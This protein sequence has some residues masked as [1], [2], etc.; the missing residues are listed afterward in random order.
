MR[1]NFQKE[2]I[3]S[4]NKLHRKVSRLDK[5]YLPSPFSSEDFRFYPKERDWKAI[6]NHVSSVLLY[7]TNNCNSS[8][9]I[10]YQESKIGDRGGEMEKE[11][12]QKV[13]DRI[14]KNKRVTLIGGEP[15]VRDDLFE[16]IRMVKEKGHEPEIFTNG[17]KLSDIKYV[18]KLK[19]AGIERVYISLDGFEE[20]IYEKMRGD[21]S[22][23]KAKLLALRNLEAM[24]MS[25]VI[26]SVI[27]KDINE[28]QIESL[29]EFGLD[30]IRESTDHIDGLLF[31][32]LT[33]TGRCELREHE[34]STVELLKLLK[35]ETN[36]QVVPEY[37]IETKKLALNISR[38]MN[39]LNMPLNFGSGGLIGLY[40]PGSIEPCFP[41]EK[42]I[43]LNDLLERGDIFRFG[44]ESLKTGKIRKMLGNFI[45]GSKIIDSISQ[46]NLFLGIGGVNNP[47]SH[48]SRMT[49]TIGLEASPNDKIMVNT[50]SFRD[51]ES[52]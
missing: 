18:K 15:T 26:A 45:S 51:L 32:G 27:G 38:L 17:L 4:K 28:D 47:S 1:G 21:A 24:E 23:L 2:E 20:E 50:T 39:K 41:L 10:C 9:R 46:G 6:R 8:C 29:I 49:G 13:L 43:G 37:L 7:I 44:L 22:Q 42:I 5:Y 12:I 40:E 30:S 25:T 35:E 48:T 19:E 52:A 31:Y 11:R 16:I 33:D 36:G 14:G 3:R 34:T